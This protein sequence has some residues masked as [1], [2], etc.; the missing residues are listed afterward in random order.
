MT[1]ISNSN[2]LMPLKYSPYNQVERDFY[3]RLIG[4]V[5]NPETTETELLEVISEVKDL[6]KDMQGSMLTSIESHP[7][8]N[9]LV[10][11]ALKQQSKS[12]KHHPVID[13]PERET[14]I[15]PSPSNRRPTVPTTRSSLAMFFP[16]KNS[17]FATPEP[18]DYP[19]YPNN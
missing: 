13:L 7:N 1:N 8:A 12:K 4:I 11:E 6:H 14:M 17:R 19:E 16:P 5:S 18:I 3:S 2:T 10:Q 15:L 9:F